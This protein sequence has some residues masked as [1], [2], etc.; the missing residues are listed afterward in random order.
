[1]S[2]GNPLVSFIHTH[3][4]YDESVG[5][6]YDIYAN[7]LV[8]KDEM[9]LHKLPNF[10]FDS[11]D[12]NYAEETFPEFLDAV[13]D[14]VQTTPDGE[15]VDVYKGANIMTFMCCS[16]FHLCKLH[17]M[18]NMEMNYEYDAVDLYMKP[19][20]KWMKKMFKSRKLPVCDQRVPGFLT[21]NAY[22]TL[23]FFT[24]RDME[25]EKTP[26]CR[27][28]DGIEKHRDRLQLNIDVL[29]EIIKPLYEDY[30]ADI[31]KFDIDSVYVIENGMKQIEKNMICKY[32]FYEEE[33][34][35]SIFNYAADLYFVYDR[36]A[37]YEYISPTRRDHFIKLLFLNK[38]V[39]SFLYDLDK[40]DRIIYNHKWHIVLEHLW[41]F[42][43]NS[44]NLEY[45]IKH[46]LK[47]LFT[48]DVN[49]AFINSVNSSLF[50]R[51]D[52]N[53]TILFPIICNK[54]NA[55]HNADFIKHLIKI[56]FNNGFSAFGDQANRVKMMINKN[57]LNVMNKKNDDIL[58][59]I[60]KKNFTNGMHTMLHDS[61]MKSLS[62]SSPWFTA[63]AD[64]S[65]H[66]YSYNSFS[67]YEQLRY[68]YR[69]VIRG[70]LKYMA[71][72][73]NSDAFT[74]QQSRTYKQVL[75]TFR[76]ELSMISIDIDK[77]PLFSIVLYSPHTRKSRRSLYKKMDE[78]IKANA[79]ETFY[80]KKLAEK[81]SRIYIRTV[82]GASESINHLDNYDRTAKIRQY[83][84]KKHR[85]IIDYDSDYLIDHHI[86]KIVVNSG[87]ELQTLY[88]YWT[89]TLNRGNLNVPYVIEYKKNAGI[90]MEGIVKQFFDKIGQ[91]L[92]DRYFSLL[93]NTADAPKY[94]ISPNITADEANFAGQ[95][96]AVLILHNA[97]I[98]FN[99]SHIYLAYMMFR[100]SDITT[101]ELF[102]Y[103]LLDLDNKTNK[104]YI[105]SCSTDPND[106]ENIS[107]AA[108]NPEYIVKEFI[109]P[110]YHI[111][112][113]VFYAFIDG[114]F[115]N[116][117]NRKLFY[118]TFSGIGDKIRMY[119]IDKLLSVYT[120]SNSA[121][122]KYIFDE[123]YILDKDRKMLSDGHDTDVYKWFRELFTT[124][125]DETL[126][127]L[128]EGFDDTL[129]EKASIDKKK[130]Y[131]SKN[132]FCSSLL[133][134]W[135]SVRGILV[136]KE[137]NI[138]LDDTRSADIHSHTCNN[139]LILPVNGY[140]KTK[141]DLYNAFLSIFIWDKK[142]VFDMV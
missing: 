66:K 13:Y 113:S 141:Q 126:K 142:E 43:E 121:Y 112:T 131:M 37:I 25:F 76:E 79:Y 118:N 35:G 85:P 34:Y 31:H 106:P 22:L 77:Y 132:A 110:A 125:N 103:F 137:Y 73:I 109:R 100:E 30:L 27:F 75:Y 40:Y 15:T 74:K 89:S 51:K 84:I 87:Q 71:K 10:Y 52:L 72:S 1:M 91:Q 59:T 54:T 46:V 99:I 50:V 107:G 70:L 58:L 53:E 60:L 93:P 16:I 135:T 23:M 32:I 68:S 63:D 102:L 124:D 21:P 111:G 119:D 45:D 49:Q 24:A 94:I 114:F 123:I 82:I 38:E 44:F 136:G 3:F 88:T 120:V 117:K 36:K 2:S 55:Q 7:Y 6:I 104:A 4:A 5:T 42:L 101:E 130:E 138:V 92:Q 26:Y 83:L 33:E 69:D 64:V 48:R 129:I 18:L 67:K 39:A 57:M 128:Y 116:Q 19:F 139:M 29:E 20:S 12:M 17:Y 47:Y 127:K 61:H 115:I 14:L 78:P 11:L 8:S 97:T 140:I 98:D 56:I 28:F 108:C 95:L 81:L 133:V 80:D 65:F 105:E 86:H 134:Y 96:L 62:R 41:K 9:E 122:K 90:D